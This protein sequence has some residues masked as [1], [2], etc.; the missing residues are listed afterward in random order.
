[1]VRKSWLNSGFGANTENRGADPFLAIGWDQAIN[2]VVAEL[3]RVQKC[4]G[5]KAIFGGSYGWSSAGRFHHVK[6]QLK[7]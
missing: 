1:M 4:F 7:P 3:N 5:N 6:T 2:L